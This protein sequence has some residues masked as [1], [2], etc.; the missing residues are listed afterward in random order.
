MPAACRPARHGRVP[1][2]SPQRYGC[3]TG[4]VP[5][6]RRAPPRTG[7]QTSGDVT[8]ERVSPK[9]RRTLDLKRYVSDLAVEA[10]A[11]GAA[12]TFVV[13]HRR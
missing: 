12:V 7:S 3:E 5:R 9:G 10:V 8:V 4:G 2:R 11:G 1:M 6:R 13:R